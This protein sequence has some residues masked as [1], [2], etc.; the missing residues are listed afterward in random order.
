LPASPRTPH[1]IPS[2]PAEERERRRQEE[3]GN[4]KPA[5]ALQINTL[6][7]RGRFHQPTNASGGRGGDCFPPKPKPKPQARPGPHLPS[8]RPARGELAPPANPPVA[9]GWVLESGDSLRAGARDLG[10]IHYVRGS[11]LARSRAVGGFRFIPPSRI[12][13]FDSK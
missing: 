10:G 13:R 6:R 1:C 12:P 8:V 11:N 9:V 3:S 5:A 7:L 2:H 4:C